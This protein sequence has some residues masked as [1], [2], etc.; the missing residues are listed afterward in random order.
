MSPRPYRLGERRAANE[1]TRA[2]IVK[3][4]RDLLASPEK[5][6]EFSIDA[7]AKHAGVARM[8]VYYQFGSRASVL[9]AVMDDLARTGGMEQLQEAF[10]NPD[11]Q[12]ALERFI[13]VFCGF[14]ASERLLI[15]RLQML[16]ALDPELRK[17]ARDEWRRQGLQVI[18]GRIRPGMDEGVDVVHMLTSFQTF[19][20]LAGESRSVDDV[21]AIVLRLAR[22]AIGL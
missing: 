14:Y 1:D 9:E 17:V 12:P 7:V 18:L 16:T 10:G 11:P 20:A 22:A 2:R 6:G 8:T 19:D 21:A 3:A 5:T 15:R 4:A 13:R